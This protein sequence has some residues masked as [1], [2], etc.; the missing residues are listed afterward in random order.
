VL[1]S[2]AQN[3][4]LLAKGLT[5]VKTIYYVKPEDE[6]L[7]IKIRYYNSVMTSS[8]KGLQKNVQKWKV[9]TAC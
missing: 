1:F 2:L 4:F 8:F 3:D 7:A 5:A 6:L 9:G